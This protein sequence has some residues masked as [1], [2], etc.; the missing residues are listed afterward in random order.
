[1]S[2]DTSKRSF[3]RSN[4]PEESNYGGN[5]RMEARDE[6][7]RKFQLSTNEIGELKHSLHY[8]ESRLERE[9]DVKNDLVEKAEQ[10]HRRVVDLEL[11]LTEQKELNRIQ[12]N[13][14]IV[15]SDQLD[16]FTGSQDNIVKELRDKFFDYNKEIENKQH[17]LNQTRVTL[18]ETREKLDDVTRERDRYLAE[19][20]AAD[21]KAKLQEAQIKRLNTELSI[22]ER[23]IEEF[24]NCKE[25]K[26]S[27][28][29]DEKTIYTDAKKIE[30]IL[31]SMD[32]TKNDY[33]RLGKSPNESQINN[34]R[35][36]LIQKFRQEELKKLEMEAATQK[37]PDLSVLPEDIQAIVNK[38]RNRQGNELSSKMVD[39]LLVECNRAYHF[40]KQDRVLK[41]KTQLNAEIQYLKRVLSL[42]IP[43]DKD[44]ARTEIAYL[45]RELKNAREDI[46][47]LNIKIRKKKDVSNE[48]SLDL[49][50]RS[51]IQALNDE[52]LNDVSTQDGYKSNS[53]FIEKALDVAESAVN[54]SKVLN[55]RISQNVHGYNAEKSKSHYTWREEDQNDDLNSEEWLI[56]EINNAVKGSNDKV[57]RMMYASRVHLK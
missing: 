46:R 52:P 16:K 19:L 53:R 17:A 4:R 7:K 29:F 6:N 23:T 13:K 51:Q 31:S 55:R 2:K 42:L 48:K 47:R 3:S 38:F 37:E 5:S 39:K 50:S 49:G 10:D 33:S 32:D 27:S 24:V 45:R 28:F 14:I 57:Q 35:P 56:S 44:K 1:M 18:M 20:E 36:Y 9:L 43:L 15:L 41:I 12:S 25:K 54:E 8:I 11:Q 30:S 40:I 26:I 21:E 34:C 22:A